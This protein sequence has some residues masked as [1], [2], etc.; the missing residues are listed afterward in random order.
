M[1]RLRS[2]KGARIRFLQR[3]ISVLRKRSNSEGRLSR[4]SWPCHGQCRV[5]ACVP[6]Q[7][8]SE[9]TRNHVGNLRSNR[10]F[11][12]EPPVE[13][14]APGE[15]KR[16]EDRSKA[17]M[18]SPKVLPIHSGSY[19]RLQRFGKYCEF[20]PSKRHK[21]PITGHNLLISSHFVDGRNILPA[22]RTE[23]YRLNPSTEN[24]TRFMVWGRFPSGR[25]R[26]E[27]KKLV[28]SQ[29]NGGKGAYESPTGVS[30]VSPGW[31]V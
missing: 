7:I 3:H 11:V 17:E 30:P 29:P 21:T 9:D 20:Y 10:R 16:R 26:K 15:A 12:N 19:I 24:A 22:G 13:T 8:L 14:K 1:I 25:A 4:L 5:E 27:N 6:Q 2:G 23:W 31:P 28:G 18:A